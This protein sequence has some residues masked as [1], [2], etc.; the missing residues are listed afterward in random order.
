MPESASRSCS[1]G[2]RPPRVSRTLMWRTSASTFLLESG[3]ALVIEAARA[4]GDFLASPR[5]PLVGCSQ[6]GQGRPFVI[7]HGRNAGETARLN[8]VSLYVGNSLV[9][10][11]DFDAVRCL[12]Q[13]F[14]FAQETC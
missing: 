3:D 13:N 7:E 12:Y 5:P 2:H 14:V 10:N 6:T 9:P 4:L 11:H 8:G 1:H